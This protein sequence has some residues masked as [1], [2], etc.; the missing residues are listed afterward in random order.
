MTMASNMATTVIES[1]LDVNKWTQGPPSVASIR[2]VR[3]PH[4]QGGGARNGQRGMHGHGLRERFLAV[5]PEGKAVLIRVRRYRCRDCGHVVTVCPPCVVP[6]RFFGRF[7][8]AVVLV[9]WTLGGRTLRSLRATYTEPCQR[10]M[11]G[12]REWPMVRR[13]VR[14]ARRIFGEKCPGNSGPIRTVARRIAEWILAHEPP[15]QAGSSW[16]DRITSVMRLDR[17]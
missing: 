7:R 8:I 4:C 15:L 5:G 11:S 12:E 3:C 13:W 1:D 9:L 2:P 14:E 16:E 17:F 6:R 10:G